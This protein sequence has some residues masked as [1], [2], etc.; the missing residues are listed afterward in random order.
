MHLLRAFVDETPARWVYLAYNTAF[1]L[2]LSS[3]TDAHLEAH[4]FLGRC[5]KPVF[6]S[7]KAGTVERDVAFYLERTAGMKRDTAASVAGRIT[8][9]LRL[10][11]NLRLLDDAI[12][13]ARAASDDDEAGADLICAEVYRLAGLDPRAVASTGRE[14]A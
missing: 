5:C 7:Y 12:V 10:S 11:T 2:V 14:D 13:A 3:T 8:R 1:R 6:D 4:A 9:A